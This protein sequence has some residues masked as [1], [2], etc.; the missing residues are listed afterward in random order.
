MS[1]NCNTSHYSGSGLGVNLASQRGRHVFG[2]TRRRLK[3]FC[4]QNRRRFKSA[5]DTGTSLKRRK[6]PR[7]GRAS[8]V[9]IG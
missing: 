9:E 8:E 7:D 6:A 2:R 3:R 4:W 5:A 1:R